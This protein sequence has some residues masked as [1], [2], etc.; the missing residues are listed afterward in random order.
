MVQ[1]RSFN[2]SEKA[3]LSRFKEQFVE[4][5]FGI[6]MPAQQWLAF[7]VL[8]G[9]QFRVISMTKTV[10]MR[11][12]RVLVKKNVINSLLTKGTTTVS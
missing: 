7:D 2:A 4:L 12:L 3:T 8:T 9:I 1:V 5:L 11:A 6:L 10:V